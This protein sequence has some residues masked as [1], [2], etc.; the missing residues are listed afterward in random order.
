MCYAGN[1]EENP[2][3][4][5]WHANASSGGTLSLDVSF[6]DGFS[7][8]E[9]EGALA[10]GLQEAY[11]FMEEQGYIPFDARL[12]STRDIAEEHGKSR[13]Y[14]DKLLSEGKILYKETSAGRITTDLWVAGYLGKKEEVDQYVKDMRAILKLINE[15]GRKNGSVTCSVCSEPR[16]EFNVNM[17][18][19]TNGI[20]RSCGFYVHTTN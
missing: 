5:Y 8:K 7:K 18:G 3:K 11:K 16:F 12:M 10:A 9:K 19:N 1:M 17:N 20:C 14:W 2:K 4:F 13:Q 6:D 15:S